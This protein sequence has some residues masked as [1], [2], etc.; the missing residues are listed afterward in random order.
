ME[1]TEEQ[2]F[3]WVLFMILVTTDAVLF[4]DFSD[5]NSVLFV[6]IFSLLTLVTTDAVLF[7]WVFGIVV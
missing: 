6:L 5:F 4:K 2:C 3:N 7:S 1:I